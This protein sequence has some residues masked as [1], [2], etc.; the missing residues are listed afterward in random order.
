MCHPLPPFRQFC[1]PFCLFLMECLAKLS[2]LDCTVPAR[3]SWDTTNFCFNPAMSCPHMCLHAST[4]PLTRKLG[5]PCNN[6][7]NLLCYL[8]RLSFAC[9]A[10]LLTGYCHLAIT[11]RWPSNTNQLCKFT[12]FTLIPLFKF[13]LIKKTLLPCH[14][15]S[16]SWCDPSKVV[17]DQHMEG[18]RVPTHLC[19]STACFWATFCPPRYCINQKPAHYP[20]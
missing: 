11:E 1:P 8:Y 15:L 9:S 19:I 2:L 7:S 18:G 12:S 13:T 4:F 14:Y 3:D 5:F 16:T 20:I 17:Q 6:A 10:T